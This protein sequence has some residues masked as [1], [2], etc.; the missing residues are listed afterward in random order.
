MMDAEHDKMGKTA[1]D[2]I[3]VAPPMQIDL[4]SFYAQLQELQEHL[5]NKDDA[6]V[7]QLQKMVSSYH[8]NRHVNE[9]HTVSAK[10]GNTGLLDKAEV[11]RALNDAQ[12]PTA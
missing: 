7:E 4:P 10:S 8:P 6:I 3:F 1:H 12:K 2:K 9:D 11:A 5:E